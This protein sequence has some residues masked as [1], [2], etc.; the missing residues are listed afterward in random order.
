[1]FEILTHYFAVGLFS[2]AWIGF[3]LVVIGTV[4][5]DLTKN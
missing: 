2:I 5:N 1:M 4:I 3:F